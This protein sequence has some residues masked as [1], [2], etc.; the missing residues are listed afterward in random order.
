MSKGSCHSGRKEHNGYCCQHN[1][2]R[3]QYHLDSGCLNIIHLN[4]IQILAHGF[5][6][7][8]YPKYGSLGENGFRHFGKLLVYC[9][10][11]LL[12]RL[13][14][15]GSKHLHGICSIRDL[16]LGKHLLA[17]FTAGGKGGVHHQR[18]AQKVV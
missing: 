4:G 18:F 15:H 16:H 11:H 1:D 5:I 7:C 2:Q 10:K 12:F 8:F 3:H 9:R 14:R 17:F 13:I 6:F